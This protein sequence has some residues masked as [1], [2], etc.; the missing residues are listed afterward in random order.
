[1]PKIKNNDV[2]QFAR[3]SSLFLKSINTSTSL[4]ASHSSNL[5]L[6]SNSDYQICTPRTQ[7][8]GGISRGNKT[9]RNKLQNQKLGSL[10]FV[11]ESNSYETNLTPIVVLK[12]FLKKNQLY[13]YGLGVTNIL[14]FLSSQRLV[15]LDSKRIFFFF[16]KRTFLW[17]LWKNSTFRNIFWKVFNFSTRNFF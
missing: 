1:M 4:F 3:F 2:N 8:E 13:P 10:G 6:G 12:I 16:F 7:E 17:L 15:F 14:P 5:I 9:M 11:F